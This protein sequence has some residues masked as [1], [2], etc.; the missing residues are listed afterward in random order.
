MKGG[1]KVN[2]QLI[3]KQLLE[4]LNSENNN[5]PY[6]KLCNS[7]PLF[8][9]Y[10]KK[11]K[12]KTYKTAHISC[13]HDIRMENFYFLFTPCFFELQDYLRKQDYIMS[14]DKLFEIVYFGWFF[15]PNICYYI[16]KMLKEFCDVET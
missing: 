15:K 6:K 2:G 8:E 7:I 4:L 11:R 1:N 9:Y 14:C 12:F 3:Q 5:E 10:L 13:D 16:N